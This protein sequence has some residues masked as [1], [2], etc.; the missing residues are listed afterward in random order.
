MD[1]ENGRI[2]KIVVALILNIFALILTVKTQTSWNI[3]SMLLVLLFAAIFV[4][5]LDV[6]DDNVDRTWIDS[7]LIGLMLAG[8]F[9]ITKIG[10]DWLISSLMV[11]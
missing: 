2:V 5:V 1:V 10:A 9:L 3:L 6:T 8:I 11:G 4:F 7:I